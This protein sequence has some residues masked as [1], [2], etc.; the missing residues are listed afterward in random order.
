MSIADEILAD[1]PARGPQCVVCRWVAG[2]PE[3]EQAEWRQVLGDP[4][5]YPAQSVQRA[6]ARRGFKAYDQSVANHRRKG[7]A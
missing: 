6:M 7:H 5:T 2:R 3:A 4:S 1:A